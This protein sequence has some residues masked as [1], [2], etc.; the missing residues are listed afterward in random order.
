MGKTINFT[1]DGKDYTLEY[2][3]NTVIATERAGF[4]YNA[5]TT[6]PID[7]LTTLWRGAFLAHHATLTTDFVD[8]L[9]NQIDT[10]GLLDALLDLYNAPI[11]SLFDEEHS[12][13][14]VKW[15]IT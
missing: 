4:D 8:G 14:V 3:R 7:M 2:T 6:R 13:N 12:K 5:I 11:T 1:I 9:L 10:K 15:T